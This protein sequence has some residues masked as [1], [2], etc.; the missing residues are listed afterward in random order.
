ME[1]YALAHYNQ[2]STADPCTTLSRRTAFDP[3]R[4][5]RL[6]DEFGPYGA[7]LV[8]SG[9]KGHGTVLTGLVPIIIVD[10]GEGRICRNG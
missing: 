5:G 9:A 3:R 1:S 10:A 2:K 4:Q 8:T 6:Q 7:P